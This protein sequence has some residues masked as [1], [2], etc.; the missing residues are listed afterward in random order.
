MTMHDYDG[1]AIEKQQLVCTMAV[2]GR[3]TGRAE[4]EKGA[5]REEN[6]RF[7]RSFI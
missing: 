5:F 4:E 2:Y 3:Q 1:V 6:N 7:M